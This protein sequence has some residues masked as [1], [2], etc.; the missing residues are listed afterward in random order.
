MVGRPVVYRYLK[1][2]DSNN[3]FICTQMAD[4]VYKH[5][6]VCGNTMAEFS[7]LIVSLYTG[8]HFVCVL[9]MRVLLSSG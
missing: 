3:I 7:P 1:F 2:N 8:F 6:T 5:V 9:L 4:T